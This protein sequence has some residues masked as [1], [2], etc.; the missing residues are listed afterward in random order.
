M[1]L[2]L[3]HWTG[4]VNSCAVHIETFTRHRHSLKKYVRNVCQQLPHA[5]SWQIARQRWA[6]LLQPSNYGISIFSPFWSALI[7]FWWNNEQAIQFTFDV[8]LFLYVPLHLTFMLSG[9]Y[10]AT[11]LRSELTFWFAFLFLYPRTR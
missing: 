5:V 8:I 3:K 9:I 7:F 10:L 1:Q 2:R 4:T 11:Y 6:N